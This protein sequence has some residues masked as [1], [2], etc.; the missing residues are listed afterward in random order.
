M[1]RFSQVLAHWINPAWNCQ[2]FSTP[3]LKIPF[4]RLPREKTSHP[5]KQA[6]FIYNFCSILAGNKKEKRKK[7]RIPKNHARENCFCGLFKSWSSRVFSA[8]RWQPQQVKPSQSVICPRP[9]AN[10]AQRPKPHNM[11]CNLFRFIARKI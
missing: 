6:D 10:T 1:K 2:Q 4:G 8:L 9:V 3:S 11:M 7:K 5:R